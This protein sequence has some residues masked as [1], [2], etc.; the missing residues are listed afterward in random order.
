MPLP[1]FGADLLLS[2]SQE[3]GG[4]RMFA[5]AAPRRTCGRKDS[6]HPVEPF[7]SSR[8]SRRSSAPYL[9]SQDSDGFSCPANRLE[10]HHTWCHDSAT[11]S[12]EL[13]CW[14]NMSSAE[15]VFWWSLQTRYLFPWSSWTTIAHYYP[16]RY[17]NPSSGWR[18]GY[19][20]LLVL[21]LLLLLRCGRELPFSPP[22]GFQQCLTDSKPR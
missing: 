1:S 16:I 5:A 10:P 7:G 20:R 11:C 13:L 8:V 3:G 14:P 19:S 18:C 15:S 6:T 21:L 9:L 17:T 22:G 12:A 4:K 2:S